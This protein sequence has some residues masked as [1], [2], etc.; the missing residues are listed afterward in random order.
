MKQLLLAFLLLTQLTAFQ[1]V[2]A[3]NYPEDTAS[4]EHAG[5][6]KGDVLKFTFD[7]SKIFPGTW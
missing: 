1:Q 6:P 2:P 7:N 5:I 4:V 3:E